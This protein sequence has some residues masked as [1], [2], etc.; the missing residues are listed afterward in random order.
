MDLEG[1]PVDT[2][3]RKAA[4]LPRQFEVREGKVCLVVGIICLVLFG[5]LAVLCLLVLDELAVLLALV[6]FLFFVLMSVWMLLSYKNRRMV[7]EGDTLTYTNSFGRTTRFRVSEVGSFR[8]RFGMGTRELRDR[9]GKLLARFEDNMKGAALLV[10]YLNQ[11][12][13]R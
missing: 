7:V 6:V 4:E 3:P 1:R 9:E 10:E 5:A 12:M 2:T 13:N 8:Y 11:H